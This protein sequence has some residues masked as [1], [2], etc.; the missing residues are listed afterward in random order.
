[1]PASCR[2]KT[3]YGCMETEAVA[4][5]LVGSTLVEF[6]QTTI[7]TLQASNNNS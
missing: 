4:N 1:M 6:Q 7:L 3:D 2:Y 5:L